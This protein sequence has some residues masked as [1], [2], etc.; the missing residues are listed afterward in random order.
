MNL[1]AHAINTILITCI[2]AVVGC[3]GGGGKEEPPAPAAIIPPEE[4]AAIT[5]ELSASSSF[6]FKTSREVHF[7]IQVAALN[8]RRAF[9]SVFS[10]FQA[11]QNTTIA[12]Y[13]SRLLM[14]E[15]LM[16]EMEKT[17]MI[18]NDIDQVF[19]QVWTD[20][21]SDEPHQVIADIDSNNRVSWSF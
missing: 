17:I 8:E 21:A 19:V 13:D 1:K 3:G 10:G 2:L 16:G 15:I 4:P 14:Q 9:V 7:D 12:K 20:K 5:Q 18:T 11:T 6:Q